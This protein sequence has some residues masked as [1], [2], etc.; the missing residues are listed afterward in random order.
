MQTL[1]FHRSRKIN[2]FCHLSLKLNKKPKVWW[3]IWILKDTYSTSGNINSTNQ[4]NYPKEGCIWMGSWA[5]VGH[6]SNAKTYLSP[7]AL[8]P[9]QYTVG[10]DLGTINNTYLCGLGLMAKPLNATK[11]EQLGFWTRKF[12]DTMLKYIP[13]E[14]KLVICYWALRLTLWLKDMI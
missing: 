3:Y 9:L 5:K 1:T 12:L 11:Q 4:H 8:E 2:C 13:L 6:V 10:H 14:R 7:H